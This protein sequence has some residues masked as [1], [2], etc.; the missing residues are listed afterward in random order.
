M[1]IAIS[2]QFLTS[3][4]A[5]KFSMQS[6]GRENRSYMLGDLSMGSNKYLRTK[7]VY[8][9]GN[10][11]SVQDWV[12]KT[13]MRKSGKWATDL[14]VFANALLFNIGIWVLWGP[15]ETRW[16][17]FQGM[18]PVLKNYKGNNPKWHLYTKC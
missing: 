5:G 4:L 1:E 18:D 6:L 8:T 15:L 17:G 14:E 13:G 7:Y 11:R 16:V 10:Y 3:S 12:N 9:Q 2:R